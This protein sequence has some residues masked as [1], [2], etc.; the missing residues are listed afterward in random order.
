M[1]SAEAH[2]KKKIE[3]MQELNVLLD[4]FLEK[5]GNAEMKKM[6]P[7]SSCKQA[8]RAGMRTRQNHAMRS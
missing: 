4:A 7:E 1:I 6:N 8:L 3:D 5:H 2:I